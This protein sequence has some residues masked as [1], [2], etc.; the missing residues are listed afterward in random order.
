MGGSRVLL[1]KDAH[2][3]GREA[4]LL[5]RQLGGERLELLVR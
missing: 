1:Q 2:Q 5:V 3:L 4:Q